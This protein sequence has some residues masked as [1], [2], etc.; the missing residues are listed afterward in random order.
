MGRTPALKLAHF[1]CLPRASLGPSS[2]LCHVSRQLY[3]QVGLTAG[4]CRQSLPMS[5]V[6]RST[7][8]RRRVSARASMA[9]GEGGLSLSAP[10]IWCKPAHPTGRTWWWKVGVSSVGPTLSGEGHSCRDGLME[11]AY[12][13]SLSHFLRLSF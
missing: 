13:L 9:D 1:D 7:A 3:W 5:Q 6:P 2:A 12:S 8:L 11:T 4:G 10:Q